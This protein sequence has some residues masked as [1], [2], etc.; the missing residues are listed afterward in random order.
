[1]NK[2][3]WEYSISG[4]SLWC[5][6]VCPLLISRP[7]PCHSFEAMSSGHPWDF[8][9]FCFDTPGSQQFKVNS[10]HASF[11]N[12]TALC[13]LHTLR[14]KFDKNIFTDGGVLVVKQVQFFI[15]LVIANEADVTFFNHNFLASATRK[16]IS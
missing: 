6:S 4:C 1:M 13:L 5:W 10:S 3:A 12:L 2:G 14:P 11:G 9:L 8:F 15:L 7:W 16:S